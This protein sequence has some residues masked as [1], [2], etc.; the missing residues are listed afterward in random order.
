MLFKSLL[1]MGAGAV[2]ATGRRDLDGLGGLIHRMPAT[3]FLALIGVT[4]ISALPPLNG[5][6]SEWLLFQA[7]LQAPNCPSCAATAGAGG[8]RDAG[9]LGRAGRRL[10]RALLLLVIAFGEATDPGG[11]RSRRSRPLSLAAMAVLAALCVLAG[12][13][14]GR[15]S[16]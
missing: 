9:A 10:F 1:F 16:T 12:I 7:V 4:A 6:A 5:F 2:A 11:G 14:P 15:C 8:G 13:A 3:A